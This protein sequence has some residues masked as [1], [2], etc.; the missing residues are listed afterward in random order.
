MTCSEQLS[1][2]PTSCGRT[3]N[4]AMPGV[5]VPSQGRSSS[6]KPSGHGQEP[7]HAALASARLLMSQVLQ[8]ARGATRLSRRRAGSPC[9]GVKA[10]RALGVLLCGSWN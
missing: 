6:P 8:A 5:P 2:P 1:G 3:Q 4:Q 9:R 7:G 10:G